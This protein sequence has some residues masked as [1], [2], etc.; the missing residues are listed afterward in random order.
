M[1]PTSRKPRR[2]M[3]TVVLCGCALLSFPTIARGQRVQWFVELA[4]DPRDLIVYVDARRLRVNESLKNVTYTVQFLDANGHAIRSNVFAFT[5]GQHA[6]LVDPKLYQKT[7]HHSIPNAAAVRGIGLNWAA[8]ASGG[9]AD[10]L[11]QQLRPANTGFAAP[12]SQRVII[13]SGSVVV[14]PPTPLGSRYAGAWRVTMR[15]RV[16]NQAHTSPAH[17]DVTGR[18]ID[19]TLDVSD[20]SLKRVSGQVPTPG[21]SV[22]LARDTG[23]NTT[24]YYR[25]AWRGN[26]LTGRFWNV[27]QHPDS[28][29]VEFRR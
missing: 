19:G 22:T 14:P 27:G 6:A 1:T 7:E 13:P 23:L 5:D 17:I 11:G 9:K 20:G 29:W 18:R 25:L 8:K 21:D 2:E 26:V 28:G 12:A 24:Q 4:P 15:S 16:S 3:W 10:D